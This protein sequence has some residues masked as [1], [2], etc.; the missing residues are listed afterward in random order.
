MRRSAVG[1]GRGAR[2]CELAPTAATAAGAAARAAV[3]VARVVI[4]VVAIAIAGRAYHDI[5]RAVVAAAVD[6]VALAVRRV[7]DNSSQDPCPHRQ[8]RV[9]RVLAAL[10]RG[11]VGPQDQ[12]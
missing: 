9:A 3:S 6:L 8:Q 4:T 2:S 12:D 7:I 11:L 10:A 1:V 5:G